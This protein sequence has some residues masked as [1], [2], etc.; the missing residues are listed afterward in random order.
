MAPL[1]D[2]RIMNEDGTG[3]IS[4]GSAENPA[5]FPMVVINLTNPGGI[6]LHKR[7]QVGPPGEPFTVAICPDITGV[8]AIFG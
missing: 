2:V 6:H 3:L 7:Y 8:M 4:T 1:G 5:A